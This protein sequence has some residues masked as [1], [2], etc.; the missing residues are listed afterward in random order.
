MPQPTLHAI[1][2][3]K[4]K[5]CRA[6][7]RAALARQFGIQE[8]W[9]AGDPDSGPFNDRQMVL[10]ER[11]GTTFEP[12]EWRTSPPAL[13]ELRAARLLDDCLQRWNE[14]LAQ[15]LAPPPEPGTL[16]GDVCNSYKGESL[17]VWLGTFLERHLLEP[18]FFRLPI[19]GIPERVSE[20]EAELLL[21]Y[22][23]RDDDFTTAWISALER[24]LAPWLEKKRHLDYA[25]CYRLIQASIDQQGAFFKRAKREGALNEALP[26]LLKKRRE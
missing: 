9:L 23:S 2:S 11:Q 22:W 17:T 19:Y 15:G 18:Y 1:L 20:R 3:G 10:A 24:L 14:D 21:W 12:W 7:K 4:T 16:L 13:T 5:R 8:G 6:S 25:A 26:V